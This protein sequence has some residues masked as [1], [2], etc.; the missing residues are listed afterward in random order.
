[1]KKCLRTFKMSKNFKKL[2]SSWMAETA[3]KH[4]RSTQIIINQI[5]EIDNI[6]NC[7]TSHVDFKR[8][9]TGIIR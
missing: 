4:I 1:M 5:K 6:R 8:E 9:L 3:I 2:N 7:L